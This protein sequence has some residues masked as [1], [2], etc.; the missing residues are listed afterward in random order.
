MTEIV[1]ILAV[2]GTGLWRKIPETNVEIIRS[3]R[4]DDLACIVCKMGLK[5]LTLCAVAKRKNKA[6]AYVANTTSDNVKDLA[7]VFT[8]RALQA[9]NPRRHAVVSFR[10][11][12]PVHAVY[13]Y[14]IPYSWLGP[15]FH[16]L[17]HC[18]LPPSSTGRG[19][20]W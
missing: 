11:S 14:V 4:R 20:L 2:R 1:P 5:W 18:L 10:A 13:I 7:F 6:H 15:T 3:V 12:Y 17:H 19:L 9:E 16:T 8:Y